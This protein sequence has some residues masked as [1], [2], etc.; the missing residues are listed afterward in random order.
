MANATKKSSAKRKPAYLVPLGDTSASVFTE[1]RTS[2]K[3]RTWKS[4]SVSLQRSY[5]DA[6]TE[7]RV[8]TNTL[9]ES[10]LLDAS[11]ALVQAYHW[12]ETDRPW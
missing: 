6:K 11:Q 12:I 7:Q 1:L 9:F 2:E 8:Y 10:D 3:G 5:V 4:Y